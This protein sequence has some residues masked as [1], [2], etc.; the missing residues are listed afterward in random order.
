MAASAEDNLDLEEIELEQQ[1]LALRKQELALQERKLQ[2]LRQRKCGDNAATGLKAQVKRDRSQ[3]ARKDGLMDCGPNDNWDWLN[4]HDEAPT[5]KQ[6]QRMSCIR[7][8]AIAQEKLNPYNPTKL[9]VMMMVIPLGLLAILIPSLQYIYGEFYAQTP[10][11][12]ICE[13]NDTVLQGYTAGCRALVAEPK[14]L[15]FYVVPGTHADLLEP[16]VKSIMHVK[17][18]EM[19]P[20]RNWRD[21]V[22]N[23]PVFLSMG[24]KKTL[25]KDQYANIFLTM[26]TNQLH[27]VVAH[28]RLYMSRS[29]CFTRLGLCA[30]HV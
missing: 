4:R 11:Q 10:C 29:L 9:M 28:N 3:R 14:R 25:S 21:A 7:K 23:E 20:V 17:S 8:R 15:F 26:I 6:M 19:M 27:Q 12:G 1:K 5:T 2:L 22:Y 13:L 24:S 30:I 16:F 18:Y